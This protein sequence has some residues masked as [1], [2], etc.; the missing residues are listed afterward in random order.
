MRQ[1]HANHCMLALYG[2]LLKYFLL[3]VASGT[4]TC[5]VASVLGVGFLVE[6]I[7]AIVPALLWRGVALMLCLGAMTVIVESLLAGDE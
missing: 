1:P 4:V 5:L 2:H 6:A 7:A 3:S